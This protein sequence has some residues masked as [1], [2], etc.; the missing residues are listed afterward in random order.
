MCAGSKLRQQEQRFLCKATAVSSVKFSFCVTPVL[1]NSSSML[2]A[3]DGL[4]LP[5][6]VEVKDEQESEESGEEEGEEEGT[7]SDLVRP[8]QHH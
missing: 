2:N 7:E 3:A 1:C 6:V 5:F 4:C 8:S